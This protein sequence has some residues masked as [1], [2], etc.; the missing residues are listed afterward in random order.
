MV[1]PAT[2]PLKA[3]MKRAKYHGPKVAISGKLG[4][5]KQLV[6][7]MINN[8]VSGLVGMTAG[9]PSRILTAL[10]RSFSR[11]SEAETFC[12]LL[13][14]ILDWRLGVGGQEPVEE[15]SEQEPVE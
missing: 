12:T 3:C 9:L 15:D 10:S 4:I 13:S 5:A 6:F 8:A 1:V 2:L 14:Y 11:T 7:L